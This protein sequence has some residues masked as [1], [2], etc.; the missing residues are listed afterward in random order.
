L[1]KIIAE[2]ILYYIKMSKTSTESIT[3]VIIKV[4]IT[5]GSTIRP[6]QAADWGFATKHN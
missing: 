3:E 1:F 6:S 2:I 4:R 5:K